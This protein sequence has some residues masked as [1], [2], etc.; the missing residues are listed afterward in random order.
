M[1]KQFKFFETKLSDMYIVQR[2][3]KVDGRGYFERLFCQEE[4]ASLLRGH[5]IVQVNHS[6]TSSA[7]TIRGLHFQYPPNTETKF[8]V[9]LR[10]SVHDV[11]VDVRKNSP[12]FLDWHSTELT[13]NNGKIL[14][15]PPGCAHGFQSLTDDCEL[16]YFHTA[17]YDA[18]TEGG[19]N[20]HDPR[21]NI[22]WPLKVKTLSERDANHSMVKD[23]WL[24]LSV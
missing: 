22:R 9:C 5:E 20:P 1:T 19:L 10:G 13:A 21:L 17:A 15:V 4:M 16:L 14:C 3:P 12:T 18:N 23:G 2:E 7:G 11:V 24:G 8:V 6:L